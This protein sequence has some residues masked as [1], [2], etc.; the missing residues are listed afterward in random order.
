[1]VICAFEN[2]PQ[3]QTSW[4]HNLL[5]LDMVD[6]HEHKSSYIFICFSLSNFNIIPLFQKMLNFVGQH[7]TG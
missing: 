3:F 2:S 5:T 6:N 1:M 4:K 7:H